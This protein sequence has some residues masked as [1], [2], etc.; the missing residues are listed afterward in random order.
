MLE[1]NKHLNQICQDGFNISGI[2]I[3]TKTYIRNVNPLESPTYVRKTL[4]CQIYTK[5]CSCRITCQTTQI[6]PFFLVQVKMKKSKHQVVE[7][8]L[9]NLDMTEFNVFFYNLIITLAS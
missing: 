4:Y 8:S 5:G 9:L 2:S 3:K 6:L 1:G 7:E